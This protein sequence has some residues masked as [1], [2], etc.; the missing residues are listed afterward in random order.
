MKMKC[1]G[2][3]LGG[4]GGGGTNI[5]QIL[6]KYCREKGGWMEL[7]QHCGQEGS[8]ISDVVPAT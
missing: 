5:G 2:K 8:D 1:P 3:Y 6:G 4:A 7:A